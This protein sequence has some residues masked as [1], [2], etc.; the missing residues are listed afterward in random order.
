LRG[1]AAWAVKQVLFHL[2]FVKHTKNHRMRNPVRPYVRRA[3]LCPWGAIGAYRYS[4]TYDF[5]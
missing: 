5:I 1:L 3:L 4:I 2:W